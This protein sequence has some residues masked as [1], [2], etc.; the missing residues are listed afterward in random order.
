MR[1]DEKKSTSM[2][3]RTETGEKIERKREE[4]NVERRLDE[5]PGD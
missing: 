1:E 5:L 4:N 3:W 2:R